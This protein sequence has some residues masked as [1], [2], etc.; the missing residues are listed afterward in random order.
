MELF[1]DC[2]I[3][4]DGT[5]ILFAFIYSLIVYFGDTISFAI[6]QKSIVHY[7]IVFNGFQVLLFLKSKVANRNKD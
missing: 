6:K 7:I 2:E 3:G 4:G 1:R 5:F